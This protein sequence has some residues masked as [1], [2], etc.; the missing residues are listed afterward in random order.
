MRV[1]AQFGKP[2]RSLDGRTIACE[3]LSLRRARPVARLATGK[4]RRLTAFSR[5]PQTA[6]AGAAAG[7]EWFD[8]PGLLE[9]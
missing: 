9:L 6:P 1:A 2:Y 5:T 7:S 8:D 3:V 4:K